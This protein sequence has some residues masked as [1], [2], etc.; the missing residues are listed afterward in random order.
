MNRTAKQREE[1]AYKSFSKMNQLEKTA[2]DE[3]LNMG[4]SYKHVGTYYL[5]DAVI[6]AAREKP[7]QYQTSRELMGKINTMVSNKHGLKRETAITQMG[8]SIE[9]AFAYGNTDY[10]LEIFKGIYDYEK[11]KV[12]NATFIL[13][14]AEKIKQ[15]MAAG[16]CFN[17]TQ[18]R[19]LIQGEVE[20]ITDFITLSNLY[21]I[22][23]ALEGGSM[24]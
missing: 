19:I 1:L 6:F 17:A 22:V 10:L 18:L 13:T 21:G 14:T 3:L 4:F 9:C 24:A 12:S 20:N 15:D 5:R 7:G 16:Q 2:S 23:H 8:Y 11:N